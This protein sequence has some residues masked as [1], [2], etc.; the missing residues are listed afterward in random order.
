MT[1]TTCLQSQDAFQ[2][3]PVSIV[4]YIVIYIVISIVN[5]AIAAHILLLKNIKQVLICVMAKTWHK[6]PALGSLEVWRHLSSR[7]LS[8]SASANRKVDKYWN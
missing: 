7:A 4:I 5:T 3:V 2:G 8:L 6:L 1:A